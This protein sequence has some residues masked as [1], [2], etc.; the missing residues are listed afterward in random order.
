MSAF[1]AMPAAVSASGVISNVLSVADA[2]PKVGSVGARHVSTCAEDAK[3]CERERKKEKEPIYVET[4]YV[5]VCDMC[6]GSG[7][8]AR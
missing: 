7:S 4:T 8:F 6:W 3:A 2:M 1:G 5:T